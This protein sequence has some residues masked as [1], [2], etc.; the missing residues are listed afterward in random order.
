VEDSLINVAV[1]GAGKFGV[2]I[3]NVLRQLERTTRECRLA[4]FAE[5][6]ESLLAARQAEFGV[7]GYRDCREMLG[8]ERIDA[9]AVA[10]PDPF[11]REP[12]VLAAQAGKHILV[13]KP[14]D[15]TVAGCEEMMAAAKRN[16]VLL[17]VDFHKRYDPY[18]REIEKIVGAG[19]MG[20]IEYGYVHMEDRIDIPSEWFPGWAPQ[21]SPVWFL[22]IHFIDLARWILKSDGERVYATGS[23]SKLRSI[24]VDTWDSI[25]AQV[26]FRNGATV[27]YD[28]S[29][30]LPKNFEAL[31]N[32]G[33]RLVGEN[34]VIEC[35]TQYRG[36]RSCLAE[37]GMRTHNLGFFSE[38]VDRDGVKT[39]SGYGFESVADFV[40]NVTA[41][42]RGVTIESI[43][44]SGTALAE[45]GLEA[46]RIALAIHDSLETGSPVTI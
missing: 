17:Q 8:K 25:S 18:H 34:G 22:G 30:I 10:T 11:H 4:A 40:R 35:D 2:N 27:S 3:L 37:E 26:R 12:A 14:M 31:V 32:Q 20:K 36:M 21:S 19:K 42:R 44:R 45:D 15:L 1:I 9:I 16:N 23:R 46:T 13:E 6:D 33:I 7:S 24:G 39:F 38:G 29:W 28:C 43:R 41:L 5:I